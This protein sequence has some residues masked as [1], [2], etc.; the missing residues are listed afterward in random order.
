M[1][2]GCGPI[3]SSVQ[4]T[5]EGG[6]TELKKTYPTGADKQHITG[7]TV[8]EP[9]LCD[10]QSTTVTSNGS[11]AVAER[12]GV[13]DSNQ[14][15]VGGAHHDQPVV[16]GAHY[17]KTSLSS[18]LSHCSDFYVPSK[19]S[20]IAMVTPQVAVVS[21]QPHVSTK[22]VARVLPNPKPLPLDLSERP[23]L[24][25]KA[26]SEDSSESD[27]GT[28]PLVVTQHTKTSETTQVA[29]STIPYGPALPK[30]YSV[31]TVPLSPSSTTH[32]T[33][34]TLK[35]PSTTHHTSPT[36]KKPSSTTHHTS[37]TLKKLKK[38]KKKKSRKK[39]NRS[40][41][42]EEHGDE[43]VEDIRGKKV[44]SGSERHK[45][46]PSEESSEGGWI[47][48]DNHCSK[49]GQSKKWTK[50]QSSS[51]VV[52]NEHSNHHSRAA[53]ASGHSN[54][55]SRAA[56]ASGHISPDL[57]PKGNNKHKSANV[58]SKV[59]EE[60]SGLKGPVVVEWD[61][62]ARGRGQVAKWDGCHQS[63]V[64]EKLIAHSHNKIGTMVKS[65]DGGENSIDS[66]VSGKHKRPR[67]DWDEELDR[68]KVK[69][70]K[71]THKKDTSKSSKNAFQDFQNKKFLHTTTNRLKSPFH[72]HHKHI[73][74]HPF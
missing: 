43:E 71:G 58:V 42:D 31:A 8:L 26:D 38:K 69:K 36:L 51:S 46:T 41:S 23:Q 52:T 29:C 50:N 48:A 13:L 35:K 28:A 63:D 20:K 57:E 34:P 70:V 39:K 67:D 6:V 10:A 27:G 17:E 21:P 59:Q 53:A 62:A 72:P 7:G 37:P 56:A 40:H 16:G 4:L 12:Q 64:V 22:P 60:C 73:H 14:P 18:G 30:D 44:V 49:P 68:G 55:H 1:P 33:S 65:W 19:S 11:H 45:H 47:P 25:T 15:V 24:N 32:H 61:D 5:P 66:C 9:A 2:Q 3:M 54:H 74:H